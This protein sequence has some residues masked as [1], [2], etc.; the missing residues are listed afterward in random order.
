MLDYMRVGFVGVCGC[1]G[2]WISLALLSFR[3]TDT[4]FC[5]PEG[6]WDLWGD[7]FYSTFGGEAFLGEWMKCSF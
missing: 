6:S 3:P 7:A 5:L 1:F 2:L 4:K